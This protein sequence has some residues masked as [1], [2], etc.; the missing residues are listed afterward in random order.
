MKNERTPCR[1]KLIGKL[2]PAF[3]NILIEQMSKY[4]SIQTRP[5]GEMLETQTSNIFDIPLFSSFCVN[6]VILTTNSIEVFLESVT[7][8]SSNRRLEMLHFIFLESQSFLQQIWEEKLVKRLKFKTGLITNSDGL[9]LTQRENEIADSKIASIQSQLPESCRKWNS[10]RNQQ[11]SIALFKLSPYV[12]LDGND[13][14]VMGMAYNFFQAVKKIYNVSTTI[15][16]S[17]T[18]LGKSKNGSWEGVMGDLVTRK[19]DVLAAISLIPSRFEAV[20]FTGPINF[21]SVRVFLSHPKISVKWQAILYP[22]DRSVWFL[23]FIFFVASITLFYVHLT[24]KRSNDTELHDKMYLAI[25]IPFSALVQASSGIPRRAR[26]FTAITLFYALILGQFYC[27]N[28]ISF[29]TFPET[30][31]IPRSFED[32]SNR[33]DYKIYTMYFPGGTL[34]MFLNE[35]KIDTFIK[36]RERMTNLKDFS[37]CAEF[38]IFSAKSACIGWPVIMDPLIAKNFTLHSTFNP[39]RTTPPATSFSI[40][41]L[42][43]KYSKHYESMNSIVGWATDTGQFIKWRHMTL[44]NLKKTGLQWLK[45]RRGSEPYQRLEKLTEEFYTLGTKP[46]G[47]ENFVLCFSSLLVGALLALL[48]WICEIIVCNVRDHNL[49][50]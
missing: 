31:V 1:A 30:E 40:H 37:K 28:L 48:I 41:V 16:I 39:L 26:F 12:V 17:L 47:V 14:P 13:K 24:L 22:F 2:E 25:V 7:K 45:S 18:K 3:T 21:V 36:I 20:D 33:K 9:I 11:L 19:K 43:Q 44:D 34:D 49:N 32:L 23:V 10:I 29:L 15:E 50:F 42:L 46:F 6:I 27:S 8:E 35:T 4:I 5:T 38:A